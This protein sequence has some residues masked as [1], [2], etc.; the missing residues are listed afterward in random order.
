MLFDQHIWWQVVW[1][2]RVAIMGWDAMGV[3]L[4][5]RPPPTSFCSM[6]WSARAVCVLQVSLLW[7]TSLLGHSWSSCL[8]LFLQASVFAA[9]QSD[10]HGLGAR[11]LVESFMPTC[12]IAVSF[13]VVWW[14]D[15]FALS[16]YKRQ[17]HNVLD[18]RVPASPL[19]IYFSGLSCY[20]ELRILYLRPPVPL[21][22]FCYQ[23]DSSQALNSTISRKIFR[24]VPTVSCS[25]FTSW[26]WKAFLTGYSFELR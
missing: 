19:A 11:W 7:S 17:S 3:R 9:I 12:H 8:F 25:F 21:F 5:L 13:C 10:M 2:Q 16:P 4:A 24:L 1:I 18:P 26:S 6:W 14:L 15:A 22:V 20:S 23:S